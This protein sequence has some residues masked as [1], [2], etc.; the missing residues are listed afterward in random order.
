MHGYFRTELKPRPIQ[1]SVAN[2]IPPTI[3]KMA[4]GTEIISHVSQA[5]EEPSWN[6][7]IC[8][9]RAGDTRHLALVVEQA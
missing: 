9:I 8:I 5:S 2:T 1:R 3:Q 7:R 6:S 4:T